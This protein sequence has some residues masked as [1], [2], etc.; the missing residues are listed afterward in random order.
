MVDQFIIGTITWLHIVSVIGWSGGAI[1]NLIVISPSL[2]KLSPQANGE[3][4][5]K[6]FP[7]FLRVIQ[8]FTVFT[9]TFGPILA[10]L[11]N[12]GPPNQFD[13]VSPWSIFVTLGASTGIVMFIV[14][15]FLLTPT[16]KRLAQVVQQMQQDPKQ[17]PPK[18]FA[19]LRRRMAIMGPLSVALLLLAEVFMVAAAQF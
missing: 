7:R 10:Y 2:S 18:Q 1:I 8:A 15:F 17:P 6:M 12:D 13:L 11:L 5:L 16:V 9:L 19:V 14:V 4:V 3:L